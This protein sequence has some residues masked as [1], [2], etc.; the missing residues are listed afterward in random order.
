MSGVLIEILIQ[1]FHEV[2]WLDNLGG[3]LLRQLHDAD[4]V[5]RRR[6]NNQLR[7]EG[8]KRVFCLRKFSGNSE[9]VLNKADGRD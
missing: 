6:R 9:R 7:G 2:R 3:R 8:R 5:L 1:L 4:Y